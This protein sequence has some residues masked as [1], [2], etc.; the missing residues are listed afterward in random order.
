MTLAELA[1]NL[2]ARVE[3]INATGILHQ[4]L[5]DLGLVP[6]TQVQVKL[7]N[8]QGD[9]RAYQI[10]GALIALRQETAKQIQIT[11]ERR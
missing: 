2:P 9:P 1:L 8:P 5:L 10:R 3:K 4:R 7:V 6:S 11:L